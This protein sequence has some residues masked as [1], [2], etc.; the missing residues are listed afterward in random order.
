MKKTFILLIC[1]TS[2]LSWAQNSQVNSFAEYAKINTDNSDYEFAFKGDRMEDAGR[3][4]NKIDQF[5]GVSPQIISKENAE[6]M[7]MNAILSHKFCNKV[8]SVTVASDVTG[9]HKKG[10]IVLLRVYRIINQG[11]KFSRLKNLF[12]FRYKDEVKRYAGVIKTSYKAQLQRD[13]MKESRIS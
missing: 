13:G 9:D 11:D 12:D 7:H 5:L 1:L 6:S 8:L 10:F 4:V 3:E 2:I